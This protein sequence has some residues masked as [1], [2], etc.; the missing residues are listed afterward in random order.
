VAAPAGGGLRGQELQQGED[1][2]EHGHLRLGAQRRRPGQDHA[3]S[4]ATCLQRGV[5]CVAKWAI[6]VLGGALGWRN[7]T[8]L[9][10]HHCHCTSPDSSACNLVL[11]LMLIEPV[12]Y[13]HFFYAHRACLL[14]LRESS[15]FVAYYFFFPFIIVL[16]ILQLC[17]DSGSSAIGRLHVGP[18]RDF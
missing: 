13:L 6:Q 14:Y 5:C 15:Y 17:R 12:C 2:A 1:E 3:D 16:C 18:Q 10:S 4:S 7:M 9:C 8:N 11:S